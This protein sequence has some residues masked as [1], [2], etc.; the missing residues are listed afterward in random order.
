M[1]GELSIAHIVPDAFVAD[2]AFGAICTTRLSGG[3]RFGRT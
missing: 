1:E 2:P 3:I